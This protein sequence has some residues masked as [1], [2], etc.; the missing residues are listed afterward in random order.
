[1]DSSL[2]LAYNSYVGGE[3]WTCI[4]QEPSDIV[5]KECIIRLSDSL[6]FST[7]LDTK[8]RTLSNLSYLLDL[9][10]ITESLSP[11]HGT[12]DSSSSRKP[13]SSQSSKKLQLSQG[14]LLSFPLS[15]NPSYSSVPKASCM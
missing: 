7:I 3:I 10:S 6:Y 11:N 8:F 14:E 12:K 13:H 1:M 2:R 9:Y 15:S 5:G 4:L